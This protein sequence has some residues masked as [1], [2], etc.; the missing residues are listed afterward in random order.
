MLDAIATPFGEGAFVLLKSRRRLNLVIPRSA[1][2][3]RTVR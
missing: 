3:S 2:L 1:G